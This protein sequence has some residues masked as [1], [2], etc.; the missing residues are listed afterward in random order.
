MC[1]RCLKFGIQCDGYIE[2][3]AKAIKSKVTRRLTP[4]GYPL[5][6]PAFSRVCPLAPM[7]SRSKFGTEQESRYFQVFCT[8][9]AHQLSGFFEKSLWESLVLQACETETPLRHAV[10]ALGALDTTSTTRRPKATVSPDR[11]FAF[12]EYGKAVSQIRQMVASWKLGGVCSE[13]ELRTTL[14]S[15]LLFTCFETLNGCADAAI[16]QIQGGVRIIEEWQGEHVQSTDEVTLVA[17][18]KPL[19][20]EDVLLHA[21]SILELEAMTYREFRATNIRKATPDWGRSAMERMPKQFTSLAEAR[22]YLGVIIRRGMRFGAWLESKSRPSGAWAF[23][24]HHPDAIKNYSEEEMETLRIVAEYEQWSRA[25]ENLFILSRSE[26]G[27]SLFGGA[28]ILRLIYLM[29]T[30]VPHLFL[31]PIS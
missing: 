11:K 4:K 6:P 16:M 26:A 18:P 14:I 10:I 28:T 9:T 25:F 17:S 31:C 12:S 30:S 13:R 7:P 1:K 8:Q 27:K 23:H 5:I 24:F 29:T 15:C 19:I 3:G 22:V 20:I 2:K 21:F